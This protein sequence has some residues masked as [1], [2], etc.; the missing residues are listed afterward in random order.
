MCDTDSDCDCGFCHL[1]NTNTQ[2]CGARVRLHPKNPKQAE[3]CA[4]ATLTQEQI[5]SIIAIVRHARRTTN[6]PVGKQCGASP[7][8][9][10]L[11]IFRFSEYEYIMCF[12]TKS[13]LSAFIKF[14][15][16]AADQ[17][18]HDDPKPI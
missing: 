15:S 11:H 13:K 18:D 10:F 6:P 16:P 14:E 9:Y 3:C 2:I 1:V 8:E 12:H 17:T 7:S 4:N 5:D